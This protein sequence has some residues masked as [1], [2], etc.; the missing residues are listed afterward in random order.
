MIQYNVKQLLDILNSNNYKVFT[1]PYEMNIVG[2]RSTEEPNKF[3]D[4]MC[5]FYKNDSGSWIYHQYPCTTDA[6]TYFL[7]NPINKLGTAMLKE[8]QWLNAYKIG[9]HRGKYSALTQAKPV[10]TYRDFDRNAIFDFGQN[11]STGLYGINI[12]KSGK[13]S[14]EVNNWSAGCQVFSKTADFDA[15]MQMANKQKSLY[16][17]EFTYTLIDQRAIKKSNR[18]RMLYVGIAMV[19]VGAYL[20]IKKGNFSFKLPK[21]K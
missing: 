12:H 17:N 8:G 16:G 7:L 2:I 9:M 6:G 5:I 20:I 21:W 19:G 1:R 18:R 14:S 10:T 15:F 4:A 3:D 13:D 11:T